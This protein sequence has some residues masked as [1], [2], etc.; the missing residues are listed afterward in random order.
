MRVSAEALKEVEFALDQYIQEVWK[1]PKLADLSKKTYERH[2]K[3]FVRWLKD[4]FEPGSHTEA[5][6]PR[7]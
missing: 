3:T 1:H 2:A 4:D 6:H 7:S 5:G